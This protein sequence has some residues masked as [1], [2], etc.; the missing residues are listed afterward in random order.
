M[1]TAKSLQ[2]WH[3]TFLYIILSSSCTLIL[4]L[5]TI[6]LHYKVS[7]IV[8]LL[9]F[10]VFILLLPSHISFLPL[11]IFYYGTTFFF[12]YFSFLC[13]YLLLSISHNCPFFNRKIFYKINFSYFIL[14]SIIS[15]TRLK[16]Q[17]L[18]ILLSY[19]Q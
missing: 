10:I 12:L 2:A 5:S 8:S 1:Q 17:H 11:Y 18:S 9:S 6:L 19:H 14:V 13:Y 16:N 15:T 7:F 3:L 4:S